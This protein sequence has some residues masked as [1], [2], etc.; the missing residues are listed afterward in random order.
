MPQELGAALL[1]EGVRSWKPG[2]Y[3]SDLFQSGSAGLASV[4]S[5][6][7]P[8]RP[9]PVHCAMEARLAAPSRARFPLTFAR[10]PEFIV[11]RRELIR[12]RQELIRE[13]LKTL[14]TV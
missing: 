6:H 14:L 11:A 12:A 9:V 10:F 2:V 8:P 4:G 13:G 5:Q 3:R 1:S 7:C